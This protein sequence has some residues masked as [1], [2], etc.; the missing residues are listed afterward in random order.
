MSRVRTY[1][2]YKVCNIRTYFRHEYKMISVRTYVRTYVT[3]ENIICQI[4]CYSRKYE[5]V[6]CPFQ[7]YF[8][9]NLDFGVAS[10]DDTW[11]LAIRLSRS[12]QY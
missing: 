11:Q 5:N 4:L 1:V 2:T 8:F 10:I 7:F 6:Y 3:Y 9:E 12:C